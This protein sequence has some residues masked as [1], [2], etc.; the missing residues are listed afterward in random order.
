MRL[1]RAFDS[2]SA[3]VSTS[4]LLQLHTRAVVSGGGNTDPEHLRVCIIV[5]TVLVLVVALL[6]ALYKTIK[7]LNRVIAYR[8]HWIALRCEGKQMGWL[9]AR[10]APAFAGWGEQRFK[11]FVI[12]SGDQRRADDGV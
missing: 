7:E 3:N 6:P 1:L 9:S 2:G 11:D 4:N 5:L 12:K 8:Q 10:R